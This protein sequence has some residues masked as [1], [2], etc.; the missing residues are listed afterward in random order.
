MRWGMTN[1]DA[2]LEAV[3]FPARV[4]DLDA[5]VPMV[6][7][8][9]EEGAAGKLDADGGLGGEVERVAGE[10]GEDVVLVDTGRRSHCPLGAPCVSVATHRRGSC[11]NHAALDLSV[12]VVPGRAR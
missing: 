2:V 10:A 9:H 7:S 4:A 3:K 11:T 8:T 12:T 5:G 6:V 1:L